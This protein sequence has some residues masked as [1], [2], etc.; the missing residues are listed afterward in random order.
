MNRYYI[1]VLIIDDASKDQ[2]FK[3]GLKIAS[4][5]NLPFKLHVL[6]NPVNQGYGGNHY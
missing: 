4:D 1:E 5:G 3:I 2:T 6:F